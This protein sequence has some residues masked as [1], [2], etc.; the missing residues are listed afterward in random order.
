M[1]VAL[2]IQ[3]PKVDV[4]FIRL[5]DSIYE[6]LKGV[7]GVPKRIWSG[8]YWGRRAMALEYLGE[9]LHQSVHK[10][11]GRYSFQKVCTIA[12]QL[13]SHLLY[14]VAMLTDD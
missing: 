13:V 3:D 5:E 7:P 12:H 4:S 8:S 14:F 10:N 1:T 9:S 11:L 2:K 6:D